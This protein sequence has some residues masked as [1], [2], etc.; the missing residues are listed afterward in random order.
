MFKKTL[1]SVVAIATLTTGAMAYDDGDVGNIKN[2]Y[3]LGIACD[4]AK[5]YWDNSYGGEI[6]FQRVS[7]Y[8]N[9]GETITTSARGFCISL[10]NYF[11]NS[12]ERKKSYVKYLSD[13]YR[14]EEPT[15]ITN[16]TTYLLL[17]KNMKKTTMIDFAQA[18][19]DRNYNRADK[20]LADDRDYL[21]RINGGKL[22]YCKV[23]Y[24]W[25]TGCPDF[26]EV[27]DFPKQ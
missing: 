1:L 5:R 8:G 22:G 10:G 26:V 9:S 25:D 16:M 20:I 3:D 2:S 15:N 23:D 21:I 19:L 11:M 7:I 13:R 12:S 18:I 14:I 27:K 17:N 6:N 24:E 4:A